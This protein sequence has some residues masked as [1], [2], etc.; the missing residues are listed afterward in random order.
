MSAQQ[1]LVDIV[2]AVGLAV[3]DDKTFHLQG[4]TRE[5]VAAWIARQ[6]DGCGFHTEPCGM[7]W[8][9]LCDAPQERSLGLRV[10]EAGRPE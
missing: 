6:L 3:H 8:G 4:K 7:S 5:E 2:F 10:V 1:D 9:V